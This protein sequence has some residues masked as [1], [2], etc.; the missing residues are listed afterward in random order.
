VNPY[1]I[2]GALVGAALLFAGGAWTGR[3]WCDRGWRA[4]LLAVEQEHAA[5]LKAEIERTNG[6]AAEL[7]VE[8]GKQRVIY[9]EITKEVAKVVTR[10]VYRNVCLDDDGL[11]L[12]RAA[13]AGQAA[14]P[15]QPSGP[16]P[17]PLNPR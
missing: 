9:K 6:V 15:S 7:E 3:E 14:G 13:I 12:A 10:D 5:L 8:R 4:E 17:R 16:V 2:I 1:L 11:R